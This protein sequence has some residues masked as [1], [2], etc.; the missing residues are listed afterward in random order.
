MERAERAASSAPRVF[1]GDAAAPGGDVLAR[2]RAAAPGELAWLP[3]NGR[4]FAPLLRPGDEMGIER[5]GGDAL[6]RGDLALVRCGGP[7]SVRVVAA[8]QPPRLGTLH[9]AMEDDACQ[10]HGRVMAV[11]RGGRTFEFGAT[12]RA[13]A[14]AM[15]R[16][17][18]GAR[19]VLGPALRFV[20]S[21]P[22]TRRMRA[23]H[24]GQVRIRRAGPGDAAAL[25]AFAAEALPRMRD[26]IARQVRGRWA[27]EGFPVAAFDARG[28]VRG[29][30]FVDE[31]AAEGV[32]LPGHW[33]RSVGVSPWARRLGLGRQL[34]RAACAEAYRDGVTRVYADVREDNAASLA[35]FRGLGFTEAPPELAAAANAA[36]V[37]PGEVRR[38]IFE[39]P[40]PLP[41]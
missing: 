36:L 16:A 37:V 15:Q 40:L 33:V 34:V 4:T 7:W 10:V 21:S 22:A 25:D 6:R 8:V 39:S 11:R 17:G 35:M 41:A 2:L 13:A 29:F 27:A 1:S 24:V 3:V 19:R 32:A 31:Y 9:G 23:R 38:V 5:C 12:H 20:R 18:A 14:W 30:T 26:L 28:T